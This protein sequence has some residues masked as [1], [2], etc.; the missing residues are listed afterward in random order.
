MRF[1]SENELIEY[2]DKHDNLVLECSRGS[3][4]FWKFVE[5]YNNFYWRCAF[6]GHESNDDE[7][8]LFKKFEQR[9]L[10]HRIIAETILHGVC[11]DEDAKKEMYIKA[12]R[13][14]SDVAVSMLKEVA[15]K[16]INK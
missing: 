2:F 15:D 8:V 6:D 3:L 10:P 12:N 5:K 1:E 13:F 14:G 16:Y 7:R 9:I 4:P 11:T